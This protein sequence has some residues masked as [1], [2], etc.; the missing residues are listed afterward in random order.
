MQGRTAEQAKAL[1]PKNITSKAEIQLLSE[2]KSFSGNR[3]SSTIVIDELNP[4][5]L[6]SLIAFYE[7]R[8]FVSG[9]LWQINVFDQMGVELGKELAKSYQQIIESGD[10]GSLDLDSSTLNLLGLALGKN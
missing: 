7:H 6:G 2:S 1:L 4:E 3:P 8:S 10:F 9:T 5:A